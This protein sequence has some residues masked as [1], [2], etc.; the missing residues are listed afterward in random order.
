MTIKSPLNVSEV[1]EVA[2]RHPNWVRNA[3]NSGA[4][5]GL[6]RKPRGKHQFKEKDVQDWI[7][8]GSP[9]MPPV[10]IRQTGN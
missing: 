10:R 8:A 4:L 5:K 2:R 1:A 9:E 7:D 3:A 6:P